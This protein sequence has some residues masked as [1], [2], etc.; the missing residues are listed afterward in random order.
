M[1]GRCLWRRTIEQAIDLGFASTPNDPHSG[2]EVY[3]YDANGA[4]V[5]TVYAHWWIAIPDPEDID[6]LEQPTFPVVSGFNIVV[7]VRG[8]NRT[9][10]L[11]PR[12][13]LLFLR[14]SYPRTSCPSSLDNPSRPHVSNLATRVR[15]SGISSDSR[16]RTRTASSSTRILNSAV[17]CPRRFR[18]GF[19]LEGTQGLQVSTKGSAY[20][21]RLHPGSRLSKII[22]GIVTPLV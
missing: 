20:V 8:S 14:T 13:L 16:V 10:Y 15:R 11:T 12:A 21:L 9:F 7:G 22:R 4:E 5:R 18:P 1:R 2:L 17:S 6:T 3:P 19:V